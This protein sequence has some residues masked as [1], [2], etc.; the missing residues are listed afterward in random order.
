MG[1]QKYGHWPQKKIRISHRIIK[2]S[3]RISKARI[4]SKKTRRS[5]D[6]G[7]FEKRTIKNSTQRYHE[8]TRLTLC[9]NVKNF[10]P[11]KANLFGSKGSAKRKLGSL[12]SENARSWT[13]KRAITRTRSH[14]NQI[15]NACFWLIKSQTL[16]TWR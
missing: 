7:L 8:R 1:S 5:T 9:R 4:S 13:R 3:K 6:P 10:L 11:K 12:T 16:Q 2:S 14:W 15:Q